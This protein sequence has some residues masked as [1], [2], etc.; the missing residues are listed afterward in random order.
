MINT[1]NIYGIRSHF[2]F[3][4]NK[5]ACLPE[6]MSSGTIDLTQ[7]PHRPL[8]ETQAFQEEGG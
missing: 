1:L 4:L 3:K 7:S 5:H 8:K 6:D 2:S